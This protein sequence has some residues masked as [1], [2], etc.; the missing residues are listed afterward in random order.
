MSRGITTPLAAAAFS[1]CATSC[2][3]TRFSNEYL[4]WP[5]GATDGARAPLGP[6]GV[7]CT[8]WLVTSDVRSAW[9]CGVERL[10]GTFRSPWKMSELRTW[11]LNGVFSGIRPPPL[12]WRG[13]SEVALP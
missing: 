5:D 8:R 12:G 4:P 6:A 1:C 3:S 9:R 7:C 11:R 13:E 2:T 10:S